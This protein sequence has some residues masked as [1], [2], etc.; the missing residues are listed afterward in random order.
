[1]KKI[2]CPQCKR[3]I[4]IEAQWFGVN[5]VGAPVQVQHAHSMSQGSEIQCVC[6]KT[7]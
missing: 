2:E 4:E 1:M 7:L 3:V 6:G 5:A